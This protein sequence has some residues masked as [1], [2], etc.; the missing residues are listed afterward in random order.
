[1]VDVLLL[2]VLNRKTLD[3]FSWRRDERDERRERDERDERDEREFITFFKLL[4]SFVNTTK[5][6]FATCGVCW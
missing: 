6:F 5:R 1:V 3:L 2:K 4:V